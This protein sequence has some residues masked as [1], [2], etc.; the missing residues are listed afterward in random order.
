MF[1]G[2]LVCMFVCNT[3]GFLYKYVALAKSSGKFYASLSCI[4]FATVCPRVR[5]FGIIW[6]QD[7]ISLVQ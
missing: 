1:V 5:N 2:K 7:S 4:T 6:R 3:F